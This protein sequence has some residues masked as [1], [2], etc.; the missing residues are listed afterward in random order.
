[1]IDHEKQEEKRLDVKF[2]NI[3]PFESAAKIIS[4]P[5]QYQGD[6]DKMQQEQAL[7]TSSVQYTEI[8][9]H[10]I[11]STD[12]HITNQILRLV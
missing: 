10:V 1:M 7:N 3:V 12:H 4:D 8:E 6:E 2:G 5:A 9:R 11:F